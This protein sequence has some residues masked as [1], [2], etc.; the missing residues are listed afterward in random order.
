MCFSLI[1]NSV[2]PIFLFSCCLKCIHNPLLKK[3]IYKIS[4]TSS[5]ED[6][7]VCLNNMITFG[8]ARQSTMWQPHGRLSD[9]PC[10]LPLLN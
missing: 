8:M 1:K 6:R 9:K 7:H 4:I 2:L 5:K 3:L 10:L